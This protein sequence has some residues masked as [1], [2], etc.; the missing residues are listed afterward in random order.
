MGG[1]DLGLQRGGKQFTERWKSKCLVDRTLQ[2]MGLAR[3]LTVYRYPELSVVMPC[4][5]DKPFVLNSFRQLGGWSKF[6]SGSFVLENNQG[7]EVH[8]RMVNSDPPQHPFRLTIMSEI[9]HVA[10]SIFFKNK[11]M[12]AS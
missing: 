9:I 4:P 12:Q 1:S 8:F 10:L 3:T 7:K 11:R 2:R 6:L 5:G